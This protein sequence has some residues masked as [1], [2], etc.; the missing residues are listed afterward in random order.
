M[1]EKRFDTR[2]LCADLMTLEWLGDDGSLTTASAVLEDISPRGA[3]LQ[4]ES[5]VPVDVQITLRRGSEWTAPCVPVY[6]IFREFGYFVGVQ[7]PEGV[8]WSRGEFEPQHLLE[9]GDFV[10]TQAS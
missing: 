8:R 1:S 5:P 6:C 9:L 7:F 3:C 2:S 4:V 10:Q